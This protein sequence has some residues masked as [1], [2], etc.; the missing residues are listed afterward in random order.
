VSAV[1]VLIYYNLPLVRECHAVGIPLYFME[2]RIVAP[3]VAVAGIEED[4][5]IY[6]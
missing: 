2:T 5:R 6:G 4:H 3:K 1:P